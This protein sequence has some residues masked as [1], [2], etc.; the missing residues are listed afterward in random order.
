MEVRFLDLISEY[1]LNNDASAFF[2]N[3]Y[4]TL[5]H[6]RIADFVPIR[7]ALEKALTLALASLYTT[8]ITTFNFLSS[9]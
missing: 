9:R 1:D 8:S 3:E 6:I 5:F 4:I 7:L 2:F